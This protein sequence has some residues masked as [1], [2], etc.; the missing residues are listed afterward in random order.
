M[1]ILKATTAITLGTLNWN[2]KEADVYVREPFLRA[3]LNN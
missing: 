3:K 2:Q 1:R